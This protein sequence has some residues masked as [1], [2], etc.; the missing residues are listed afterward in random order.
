MRYSWSSLVNFNIWDLWNV[1]MF[2]YLLA[3]WPGDYS[4]V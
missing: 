2:G 1:P 4:E 3:L